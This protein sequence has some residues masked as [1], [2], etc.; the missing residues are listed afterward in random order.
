MNDVVD[1]VKYSKIRLFADDILY[2]EIS[3]SHD[4]QFLQNDLKS[5]QDWED[6][7]LLCFNI[8]KCHVLQTTRAQKYKIY[9]D[10]QLHHTSLST[11]DH[12]KY[13]GITIQSD[14]KWSIHVHNISAKANRTLSILRRNHKIPNQSL[15]EIAY[16]TFVRPQL[17]YAAAVWLP[18]LN[19]DITQL[20][21]INCR[22][23]RFVCNNYHRTGSVTAMMEQLGWEKLE[24]RRNKL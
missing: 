3:S 15:R 16:F 17:E 23:A 6:T 2:R 21:K 1:N 12:C 5:L 18:S 14:S 24:D 20:E 8:S 22:A 13:L 9:F 4:A 19:K 11:V 10:Y 7:W